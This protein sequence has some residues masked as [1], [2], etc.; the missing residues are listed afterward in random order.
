MAPSASSP[1]RCM[2]IGRG[3]KSSPP[4]SDTRARR[5]GRA[6]GRAPRSTP[7]SARPAR[8]APRARCVARSL[9]RQL[10]GGPGR[11]ATVM[12]IALEQVAHDRD[13]GDVGHVAQ[14]VVPSARMVAA[15]SLS[16]EF[17]APL[18]ATRCRPG[19][20]CGARRCGPS[21]RQYARR[22]WRG[23]GT[24]GPW[25]TRRRQPAARVDVC[26]TDDPLGRRHRAPELGARL[27]AGRRAVPVL[28]PH[29][30]RPRV[31]RSSRRP[32]TTSA[33][34]GGAGCCAAPLRSLPRQGP[35]R[36]ESPWWA[37]PDRLDERAAT[38][39]G[40]LAAASPQPS[41]S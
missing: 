18:M 31:D 10:V 7:G 13:V 9:D 26:V 39:L 28:P 15:I 37:P 40:L 20:R 5:S 29:A 22:R 14:R 34:R 30:D 12:P 38:V 6:A 8:R 11:G 33:S 25:P 41:A 23:C 35:P 2:S 24:A 36:T 19:A 27:R 32:T 16:T 21:G 3:P 1:L 4:G 17:L